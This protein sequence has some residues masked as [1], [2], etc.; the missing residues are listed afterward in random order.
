VKRFRDLA[1][2]LNAEFARL[3]PKELEILAE[4]AGLW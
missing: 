3:F 2:V 4:P 1:K